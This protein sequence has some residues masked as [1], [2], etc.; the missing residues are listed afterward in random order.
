[1]STIILKDIEII[2]ADGSIVDTWEASTTTSTYD[3]AASAVRRGHRDVTVREVSFF[4][5]EDIAR[6]TRDAKGGP[7]IEL[8]YPS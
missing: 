6:V 4:G 7:A 8:I 2:A 5:P 3:I 1:M